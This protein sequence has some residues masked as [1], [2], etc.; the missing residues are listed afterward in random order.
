[1][2]TIKLGDKIKLSDKVK[3]INKKNINEFNGMIGYVITIYNISSNQ[4]IFIG[5]KFPYNPRYNKNNKVIR[6]N[7]MV[8]LNENLEILT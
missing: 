6:S 7:T 8:F 4:H 2:T 5:V 1:M 3:V